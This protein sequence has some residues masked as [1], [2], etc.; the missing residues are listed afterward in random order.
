MLMHLSLYA[1]YLSARV[2]YLRQSV[3]K[4]SLIDFQRCGDAFLVAEL[5]RLISNDIHIKIG[6]RF[7]ALRRYLE[8]GCRHGQLVISCMYNACM[9]S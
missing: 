4:V 6:I 9:G 1:E 2:K 3:F 5:R 7:V 8:L